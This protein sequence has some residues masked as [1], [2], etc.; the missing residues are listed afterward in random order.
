MQ[1]MLK[2]PFSQK[3]LFKTPEVVETIRE[4]YLKIKINWN[5]EFL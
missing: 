3:N 2:L 4:V 5:I 1:D